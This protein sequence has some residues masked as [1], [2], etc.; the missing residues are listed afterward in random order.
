MAKLEILQGMP[1]RLDQPAAKKITLKAY[2]TRHAAISQGAAF[3]TA[4]C[5]VPS[6]GV[7]CRSAL[8][9]LLRTNASMPAFFVCPSE[10]EL[11]AS[12]AKEGWTLFGELGAVLAM[13]SAAQDPSLCA[14]AMPLQAV[15]SLRVHF[16]VLVAAVAC[17]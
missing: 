1:C 8:L 10:Q 4:V 6:C 17:C 12:G 16:S 7:C 2:R 14:R 11:K 3:K 13:L 15:S 9:Q 5:C